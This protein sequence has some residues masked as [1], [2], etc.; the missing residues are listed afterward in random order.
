MVLRPGGGVRRLRLGA[1]SAALLPGP[2][3]SF[4]CRNQWPYCHPG[5]VPSAPS[6]PPS[7]HR[8]ARRNAE[9][10]LRVQPEGPYLLGGHSYGGAVAVEIALLLEA[11][12]HDVGLV[13]VSPLSFALGWTGPALAFALFNCV[14]IWPWEGRC[15]IGRTGAE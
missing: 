6:F 8:L 13:V 9:D 3:T 2:I 15:L 4:V 12:G 7:H 1:C 14:S 10:I 11:W 5:L